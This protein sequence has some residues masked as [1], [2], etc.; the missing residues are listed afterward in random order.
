MQTI[1][2]VHDASSTQVWTYLTNERI[3]EG[4]FYGELIAGKRNFGRPQLRYRSVCERYMNE[5]N[6]YQNLPADFKVGKT[7]IIHYLRLVVPKL[8]K[9]VDY[10]A[11]TTKTMFIVV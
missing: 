1:D 2:N 10:Y 9:T 4:I 8:K 5:L 6:I 11:F 7:N 3:P